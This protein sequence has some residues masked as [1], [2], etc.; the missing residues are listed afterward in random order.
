MKGPVLNPKFRIA[1]GLVLVALGLVGA[2]S[3]ATKE[4]PLALFGEHS[5]GIVRKVETITSSGGS[6]RSQ[7]GKLE[8]RSSTS[9]I[10]HLSFTTKDGNPI[11]FKTTATFNTEAR[12][13]DQH[14]IIYLPTKPR[15]AKIYSARQLWLPMCVGFVFTG[16]WSFFGLRCLR[17]RTA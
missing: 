8:S 13:G 1:M 10:M 3:L 9:Y 7:N 6:R 5:T 16:V 14:P 15:T 12:V 2:T 4:I 11:E 17:P